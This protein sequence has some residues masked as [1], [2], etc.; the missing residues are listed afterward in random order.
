[1]QKKA[2]KR[3]QIAAVQPTRSCRTVELSQHQNALRLK[4][5]SAILVFPRAAAGPQ[6]RDVL[7]RE[8]FERMV[9]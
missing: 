1:M 8:V 4:V 6:T 9:S 7:E 5:R 2:K 3:G